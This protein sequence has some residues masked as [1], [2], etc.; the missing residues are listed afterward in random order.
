MPHTMINI[1]YYYFLLIYSRE[2]KTKFIRYNLVSS[3]KKTSDYTQTEI[4]MLS[5]ET[6]DIVSFIALISPV[7][8]VSQASFNMAFS[9]VKRVP[10]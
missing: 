5:L 3:Y 8:K 7:R 4:A 2:H 10:W 9:S 1:L 6:C